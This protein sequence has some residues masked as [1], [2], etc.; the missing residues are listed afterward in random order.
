MS[1]CSVFWVFGRTED[2][3]IQS[4][5]VIFCVRTD[6]F[7][8]VGRNDVHLVDHAPWTGSNR[9]RRPI[10]NTHNHAETAYTQ[11]VTLL[12]KLFQ[13]SDV[14]YSCVRLCLTPSLREVHTC[15]RQSSQ[16]G[17]WLLWWQRGGSVDSGP[18]QGYRSDMSGRQEQAV[19]GSLLLAESVCYWQTVLHQ[20][21]FRGYRKDRGGYQEQ[22]EK[23]VQYYCHLPTWC[24]CMLFRAIVKKYSINTLCEWMDCDSSVLWR[25]CYSSW[26][27]GW[28]QDRERIWLD[29]NY[30]KKK[31]KYLR[32]C[33]H[34]AGYIY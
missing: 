34:T 7:C 14:K 16:A 23:K 30:K 2:K 28:S 18:H 15:T 9:N 5:S 26:H 4:D 22:H 12:L 10:W 21:R 19:A 27:P 6:G 8:T 31:K 33:P 25:W 29:C 20:L 24:V 1:W 3:R 17:M 32:V 11:Q 13:Q